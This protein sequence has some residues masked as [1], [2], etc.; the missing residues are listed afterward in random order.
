MTVRRHIVHKRSPTCP[1]PT[2]CGITRESCTSRGSTG[3]AKAPSRRVQHSRGAKS[4]DAA[5]SA[6][7][8]EAENHPRASPR[9]IN[10]RDIKDKS[11]W[12]ALVASDMAQIEGAIEDTLRMNVHLKAS[13][14][15]SLQQK[16]IA[17]QLERSRRL[18]I[19]Q[20]AELASRVLSPEGADDRRR[21][22]VTFVTR[23]SSSAGW[24]LERSGHS[25]VRTG[26]N[27]LLGDGGIHERTL[28]VKRLMS[29]QKGLL[30]ELNQGS[31]P[32]RIRRGSRRGSC[33]RS[34]IPLPERRGSVSLPR[35]GS[36]R[37]SLLPERA[38]ATVEQYKPTLREIPPPP[39]VRP[40]SFRLGDPAPLSPPIRNAVRAP[41]SP[42][43]RASISPAVLKKPSA[44]LTRQQHSPSPVRS[45]KADS[46]G[47][48]A[49]RR[50]AHLAERGSRQQRPRKALE[51]GG[52]GSWQ[53]R[54]K[55]SFAPPENPPRRGSV[56]AKVSARNAKP[57]R[58]ASGSVSH[59]RE[60]V[61]AELRI[62]EAAAKFSNALDAT[63]PTGPNA[64][65]SLRILE[66]LV[67]RDLQEGGTECV[68]W[69]GQLVA[70]LLRTGGTSMAE[71][72][73]GILTK[74]AGVVPTERLLRA[75][76]DGSTD[77]GPGAQGMALGV[78]EGVLC[79]GTSPDAAAAL[80]PCAEKAL[81]GADLGAK[82]RAAQM[83]ATLYL[84]QSPQVA[85]LSPEAL[86]PVES[87]LAQRG[88][89]I[90]LTGL[91]DTAADTTA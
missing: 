29:R 19:E 81:T 47:T 75:L 42:A 24:S 6:L 62:G 58:K 61:M 11:Q 1:P 37:Y 80:I 54:A 72:G 39:M 88:H 70:V 10:P 66:G 28:A 12:D 65:A 35:R 32:V 38:S 76:A 16:F 68:R 64:R 56:S 87:C 25:P 21:S 23:R 82:T 18:S 51:D 67:R 50:V 52:R 60:S 7:L 74:L 46:D 77:A 20:Q 43:A 44:R 41:N 26:T 31:P 30:H 71:R 49:G 22:D 14:K 90:D 73:R 36:R 2:V 59:S 89:N 8:P 5:E 83:C 15:I 55:P 53:Q 57:M 33:R 63:G 27:T 86:R 78:A 45:P 85:A 34:S 3:T 40:T 91:G 48:G 79:P 4:A 84:C 9:D 69:V 13:A 17:S